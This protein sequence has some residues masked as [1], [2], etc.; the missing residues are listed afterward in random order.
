MTDGRWISDLAML[1]A[2]RILSS[3][4]TINSHRENAATPPV[5]MDAQTRVAAFQKSNERGYRSGHAWQVRIT[6]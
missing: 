5:F 3:K 4:D 6:G 1:G 2:A